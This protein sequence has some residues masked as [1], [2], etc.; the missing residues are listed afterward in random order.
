MSQMMQGQDAQEGK[1]AAL[2]AFDPTRTAAD[3]GLLNSSCAVQQL[4]MLVSAWYMSRES[5]YEY[6]R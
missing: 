4:S 5:A 3:G 2:N 6:K 1:P